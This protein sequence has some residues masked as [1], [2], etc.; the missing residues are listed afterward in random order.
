MIQKDSISFNFEWTY[1]GIIW[2]RATRVEQECSTKLSFLAVC[3]LI[4]HKRSA[5][6]GE[7]SQKSG[8]LAPLLQAMHV[9]H[10]CVFLVRT[11]LAI[12][13]CRYG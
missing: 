9:L 10:I 7:D 1:L 3:L 5:F 13:L 2:K 4:C 12:K 6:L 8:F 11:R